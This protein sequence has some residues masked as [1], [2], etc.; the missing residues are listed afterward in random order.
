MSASNEHSNLEQS[1]R[2]EDTSSSVARER[3]LLEQLNFE[4]RDLI[5]SRMVLDVR[6][7]LQP[8]GLTLE[9]MR[10]VMRT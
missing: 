3:E 1:A 2:R 5:C 4:L 10:R 6:Q 9:Q 7:R 8:H